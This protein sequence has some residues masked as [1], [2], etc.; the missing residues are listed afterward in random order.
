M[1]HKPELTYKD[2]CGIVNK[3]SWL[4]RARTQSNHKQTIK[5]HR[6]IWGEKFSSFFSYFSLNRKISLLIIINL[7]KKKI[8]KTFTFSP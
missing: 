7:K 8:V 5:K 2:E 4:K 1:L 3:R 6:G